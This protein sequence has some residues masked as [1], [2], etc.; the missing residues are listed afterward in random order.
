[1]E[2]V[3]ARFGH[4]VDNAAQSGAEFGLIVVRIDLEF[5]NRINDR[6]DRVGTEKR[7]LVVK[8]VGAEEVAPVGLPVDG[9][10]D[11]LRARCRGCSETACA[12]VLRDA[13]GRNSWSQREQLGEVSAV[14]GK[15]HHLPSRHDSTQLSRGALHSLGRRLDLHR[16][17]Q[18][19]N[20]QNGV[21]CH[22]LVHLQLELGHLVRAKAARS[23]F[24][25]VA[26]GRDIQ[27]RVVAGG[28]GYRAPL[29]GGRRVSENHA[30]I[31][32]DSAR[33]IP[34]DARQRGG[35]EL[36]ISHPGDEEAQNDD[37]GRTHQGRPT[38][39]EN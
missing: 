4:H 8:T 24:E 5:L 7:A 28:V 23:G 19:A 22:R 38:I 11:V 3:G 18:G 6:R 31:G 21:L 35:R 15:V 1:M 26:A 17:L 20:L 27:E 39:G 25:R 12:A 13:D 16:L 9:G 30:G 29:G 36:A 10:E 32:H 33:G 37:Q 14:Q 2:V 34:H